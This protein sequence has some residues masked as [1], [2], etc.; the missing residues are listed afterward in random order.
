MNIRKSGVFD[1]GIS[2]PELLDDDV[3]TVE[4]MYRNA[5][6]EGTHVQGHYD[7]KDHALTIQISI[8]EGQRLPV[9]ILTFLGNDKVPTSELEERINLHEG[10]VYTPV[11]VD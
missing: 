2:S 9:E 6:F 1:N 3:R 11:A 5:G 7:E 10:D 8:T 4:T